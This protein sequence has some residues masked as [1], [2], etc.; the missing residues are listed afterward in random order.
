MRIDLRSDTCIGEITGDVGANVGKAGLT[1]DIVST[2]VIVVHV[3]IDNVLNRL[4]GKSSDGGN[5]LFRRFGLARIDHEHPRVANLNCNVRTRAG[6]Q[7]HVS[8][9]L[10]CLN[11]GGCLLLCEGD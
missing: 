1:D 4:I 3:C 11:L 9:N 2:R 6:Q 5:H 10:K 7:V 8:L